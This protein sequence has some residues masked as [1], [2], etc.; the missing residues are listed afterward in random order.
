MALSGRACHG[1]EPTQL[2]QSRRSSFS[3]LTAATDGKR[4]FVASPCPI[5]EA[6]VL[7]PG[8]RCCEADRLSETAWSLFGKTLLGCGRVQAICDYVHQHIAFGYEH[9]RASRTAREAFCDRNR[10]LPGLCAPRGR[11]VSLHKH[12]GA[13]LH[14]YLG[15]IGVPAS[16]APMDFSAGSKAISAPNDTPL[17]RATTS[18]LLAG[19]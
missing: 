18:R 6:L 5:K 19:R 2:T 1:H 17:T 13:L 3:S 10:R 11:V 16:D 15:D 7:L 8:S 9:A 4:M 12:P 14:R